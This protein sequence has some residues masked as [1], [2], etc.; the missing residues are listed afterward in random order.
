[1]TV[2]ATAFVRFDRT[3]ISRFL[4]IMTQSSRFEI[5]VTIDLS[6][7]LDV[8]RGGRASRASQETEQN[9]QHIPLV[10]VVRE[11]LGHPQPLANGVLL[12]S[13]R[14]EKPGVC[15]TE[16]ELPFSRGGD[17][18]GARPN[19][20]CAISPRQEARGTFYKGTAMILAVGA[21]ALPK[22]TI[23]EYGAP[24]ETVEQD[25]FIVAGPQ[26]IGWSA[27]CRV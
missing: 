21:M 3:L 2:G 6:T 15:H 17:M 24:G 19:P 26:A 23:W 8:L 11:T 13:R 25:V 22:S 5:A 16:M 9:S 7:L 20:E 12:E 1:M 18:L 4:P 14:R 10:S 27:L